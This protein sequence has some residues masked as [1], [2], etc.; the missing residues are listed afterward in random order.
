MSDGAENFLWEE[1]SSWRKCSELGLYWG[2]FG[3]QPGE[4][5]AETEEV[6]GHSRRYGQDVTIDPYEEMVARAF[7][8]EW[9]GQFWEIFPQRGE[10]FDILQ[11]VIDLF[12]E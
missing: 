6:R 4:Q 1:N 10:L 3:G 7:H 8:L 11:T 12:H 5:W 9:N 2:V